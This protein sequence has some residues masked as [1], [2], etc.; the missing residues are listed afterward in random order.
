MAGAWPIPSLDP[1]EPLEVCL[2]NILT[3]RCEEMLSFERGVLE[4]DPDAVH[5]MRVAAR[6]LEAAL[7]LFGDCYPKR[8]YKLHRQTL[9]SLIKALGHV[10][11]RD[12]VIATLEAYR[13]GKTPA[14]TRTVDLIRARHLARRERERRAL[15]RELRSLKARRF[16]DTFSHFVQRTVDS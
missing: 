1:N 3:T 4:N 8:E 9:R 11:E 13:T 7:K 2:K 12:V 5:D 15:Q 16:S 10:R 6:R 14:D